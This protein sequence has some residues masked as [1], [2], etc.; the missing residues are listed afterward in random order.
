[1]DESGRFIG[2]SGSQ[3]AWVKDAAGREVAQLLRFYEEQKSLFEPSL[4][5]LVGFATSDD[6]DVARIG[7]D[8]IFGSIVEKL[9][10]SFEPEYC[11]F[12]DEL[13]A[14][15]IDKCRR[16]PRGKGVDSVLKSFGMLDAE[17]LLSR[18]RALRAR[19]PTGGISPPRAAAVLSRI[20]LGADVAST[21]VVVSALRRLF[22][23]AVV[24]FIGPETSYALFRGDPHVVHRDVP[25]KRHGALLE[26]LDAWVRLVDVVGELE[27]EVGQQG[28]V[29][30]D[31]D[32]RLTQLGLLPVLKDDSR[33]YHFES[34]SYQKQGLR[35]LSRLTAAWMAE[36]F[37]SDPLIMPELRLSVQELELAAK[38]KWLLGG[39]A[40]GGVASVS[41]GVGG[42]EAKRVGDV[43]EEELLFGLVRA[44]KTV[45]LTCGGDREEMLRVQELAV[46]TAERGV[47]LL[48]WNANVVLDT[49][50]KPLDKPALVLWTGTTGEFCSAILAS[51]V[52]V[53]YDSAGQHIAAALGV[54]TVSVFTAAAPERHTERWRPYGPAPVRVIHETLAGKT[55]EKQME[56]AEEA[57]RACCGYLAGF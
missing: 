14:H 22:P 1:M 24:V 27:R 2:K 42:N 52:Y 38:L 13:F 37:G 12:Y 32:S 43:F 36:W 11:A 48:R 50:T 44:R 17:A 28:L 3:S 26:R 56:I 5:A 49:T 25:Y 19:R 33:Y 8:A 55:I 6:S 39:G 54:P 20:T 18:R 45:L 35:E 57:V 34:R 16:V 47:P 40:G 29:V 15:L 7:T 53:G 41:F 51:D 31:T 10:D 23:D 4:D 46:R 9:S 30:I 21:S